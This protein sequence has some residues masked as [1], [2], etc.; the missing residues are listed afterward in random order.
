MKKSLLA[1]AIA[2]ALPAAASAQVTI[3]GL[4]D[5]A[6]G[7]SSGFQSGSTVSTRDFTSATSSIRFTAIEDLG[8]GMK[9]TVQYDLDPRVWINDGGA[10]ARNESFL[11][12]SGGFGNLRLGSPNA[13]G[14][15]TF[16]VASPL[17]TGIG[18]GY[19]NQTVAYTLGPRYSRS[20]RYDSPS[21]SGVTLSL[22]YAPGGENLSGNTGALV[23]QGDEARE[24]GL[25]YD[26][27]PI[28]LA[29][30]NVS[31]PGQLVERA[32]GAGGAAI[33]GPTGVTRSQGIS[34][35]LVSGSF[36]A[37]PT[38]FSAG[39]NSGDFMTGLTS[40][41][42][43]DGLVGRLTGPAARGFG[44]PNLE[45]TGWRVGV[46]HAMGN[47]ALMAM[48]SKQTFSMSDNSLLPFGGANSKAKLAHSVIGFR[49]DYSFSK[50]TVAY[51][52]FE[53]WKLPREIADD[54]TVTVGIAPVE[55]SRT[56]TSVGMRHSF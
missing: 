47:I 8:G 24:I 40:S 2:A 4:L 28:S 45:T 56:L 25:R 31:F 23:P 1:V 15:T 22:L 42:S 21:M 48:Y 26:G 17:G 10:I 11:G 5:F 7:N 13:I 53:Q 20:I 46:R 39:W 3:S 52:G 27:G 6:Y 33:V 43:L 30:A 14:L 41:S 44:V 16:L 29:V 9:A 38:Q 49:S 12:L 51:F 19:G 54:N 35:T 34:H 36:T 18:S 32:L 37:G 50:R 55:Q